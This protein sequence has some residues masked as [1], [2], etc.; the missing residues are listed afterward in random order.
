MKTLTL[1]LIFCLFLIVGIPRLLSLEAHWSSDEHLWLR[2]GAQFITSV[3]TGQFNQTLVAYHP[4]V[5]TMWLSG[6]Q[7]LLLGN[8]ATWY[9][10]KNLAVARWFICIAISTGLVT[11]FFLLRRLFGTW[12]AT[13]A[14][15]FL[16]V[17]PFFLA[18]TRRV[19]TDALAT[20]FILLTILLFLMFC[21]TYKEK[22]NWYRYRYL[23]FA[24]IT[25]GFACISKSYSLILLPWF[26][27][28]LWIFR[29]RN[30]RVCEF[31]YDTCVTGII[32][33]N[34]SL[35]TVFVVWPIF[36]NPIGLLLGTFL[37]VTNLF[38]QHA[39]QTGKHVYY[40]GAGAALALI[41]C[42]SYA[43]K[44]LWIVLDKV[45]WAITTPHNVEH[46][47]FGEIAADPGWLFYPVALLIKSTP[48]VLPLALGVILFLWK[49][50][51]HPH[52]SQYFKITITIGA[53]V[54]F[55][56]MFL[57]ITS[58]K[59]SRYLLPAFPMLDLLAGIGLFYTVKWVGARFK[60]RYFQKIAHVVCVVCVLLLTTV[61]VFAQHPYYS[62]YYNF[63][64]RI[65]DITK[66]F[67]IGYSAGLDIAAKYLNQKPDAHQMTVQ[68]STIG[69]QFFH[70]YF[71]GKVYQLP[72]KHLKEIPSP[73]PV[74][75]EVVYLR[76]SQ[77][78]WAPQ[79][80]TRGGQLEHVITLNGIEHVW[81]YRVR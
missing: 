38:F 50:R 80:G 81:I 23:I 16:V 31:L 64:W 13:S 68:V 11:A 72:P 37:L 22:Q 75:Y 5:T 1:L 61:P 29:T 54:V 66:I 55:F 19:H 9:S 76:D 73:P 17:D 71:I 78:K 39:A 42:T 41:I 67:T 49:H 51:K 30:V 14:W 48:F 44:I 20:I 53:V 27:V 21:I 45:G 43:V 52:F 40:Y 63:C 32:F 28:C 15:T 57:S 46:F 47:F 10:P 2:R 3:Q 74:G 69:A 65:T 12:C 25:F 62:T 36:W 59:F 77:I 60:K 70:P 24:S 26:F 58:K 33:L 56:I 18:Q 35:L 34:W 7:R 79:E 8:K 4:G 6:I